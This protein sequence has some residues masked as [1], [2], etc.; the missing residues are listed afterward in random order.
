MKNSGAESDQLNIPEENE[1]LISGINSNKISLKTTFAALNFKNYRL[2]FSGQLISL[3]GSWMQTTAYGYF[4]FEL[5]HSPAFLGY[6][7][8]ASGIPAW[9]LTFYGGV[10]ADRYPRRTILM[11]TQTWMM[12][13]AFVLA[14]F[15][16]TGIVQPWHLIFI[17]FLNGIGNAFDS[18]A[19]HAFARELVGKKHLTNAI[20]LNSTMFN[21]ATAIGPA[22]AGITYAILGPAWCFL[23]NG[24]S[25]L[26]VIF[27][28]WR[29]KLLAVEK[30]K[31]ESSV[32]SEIKAGFSYLKNRKDL[33]T[34]ISITSL[35][36]FFGMGLVTLF[37]AWAVNIL[38]GNSITNGYLQSARGVGA[39]TFA[40]IIA[41]V[42]HIIFRGK[43]LRYSTAVLPLLLFIFSFNRTFIVS[44]I[45]LILIGGV[46]ITM[47]NLSNGLIQTIVDEE[48]RGRIL[49]FYSFS[50]F[51]LYPVGSLWIGMLAEHF[52]TPT[53]ILINSILL[54]VSYYFIKL[55]H[56]KLNTIK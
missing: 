38:H 41:A 1:E 32:L 43:Y 25:Y 33:V 29:I 17:S 3:F 10:I 37:P 35:L 18:T 20:A 19:R 46:L 31:S 7:G 45:L 26:A 28:L 55:Y 54:A 15:T 9:L 47:F 39:V 40:L 36:S 16:F 14:V 2:W 21:T 8:F 6:V 12:V 23:I 30:P 51:A 27:N 5:T 49:S 42:N 48:F 4:I 13:L 56:P 24:I 11:I 22:I 44:I 34:I 50:F 53:A 52:S